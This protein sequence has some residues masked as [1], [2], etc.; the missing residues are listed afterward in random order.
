M[1]TSWTKW[2]RID[3]NEYELTEQWVRIDQMSTIDQIDEYELT[4]MRTSWLEYELTGNR[5]KYQFTK[6]IAWPQILGDSRAV[7]APKKYLVNIFSLVIFVQQK[8][9]W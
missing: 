5:H 7:Q 6:L 3:Q 9:C 8:H 4:K 2:G 1:S